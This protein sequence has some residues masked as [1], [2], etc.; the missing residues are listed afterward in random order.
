MRLRSSRRIV[1]AMVVLAVTPVLS[2]MIVFPGLGRGQARR[3]AESGLEEAVRTRAL[4]VDRA[5]ASIASGVARL[6]SRAGNA[7][8]SP[9]GP[10]ALEAVDDRY[11]PL[12]GGVVCRDLFVDPR[13]DLPATNVFVPAPLDAEQR[14]ELVRSERLDAA[15]DAFLREHRLATLVCLVTESGVERYA[16][17]AW[18][19]V[20]AVP[21]PQPLELFY[22]IASPR[23][24]PTHEPVWSRP[25]ETQDSKW[26]LT[27]AAP[28]LADGEFRG[29]VCADVPLRQLEHAVAGA[30]PVGSGV[31]RV[32]LRADG[33]AFT[34]MLPR[35]DAAL[36]AAIPR[37]L[38][39]PADGASLVRVPPASGRPGSFILHAPLPA[40]ALTLGAGIPASAPGSGAMLGAFFLAS[41]LALVLAVAIGVGLGMEVTRPLRRLARRARRALPG[42]RCADEIGCIGEAYYRMRRKM[43]DRHERLERMERSL[44]RSQRQFRVLVENVRDILYT[45]APDG[46]LTHANP[47]WETALGYAA[48]DVVGT[49]F[50]SLVHP[51]DRGKWE[52]L[53]H[54]TLR[55]ETRAE[56]V[57]Y[58]IADRQGN[59]R[60]HRSEGTRAPDCDRDGDVFLGVA[61]DVTEQQLMEKHLI[62]AQKMQSIGALAGGVA[63]DIGNLLTPMIGFSQLLRDHA[64]NRELIVEVADVIDTNL[65]KLDELTRRLLV[66]GRK[67]G[68][69]LRPMDLRF[70]VEE[71]RKLLDGS[72]PRG[73]RF[74]VHEKDEPLILRGDPNQIQQVLMNLCLNAVDAMPDGGVLRLE[75]SIVEADA[76]FRRTYP[77]AGAAPRFARVSVVDTGVGM[78]E[79]TTEKIFEPFFTTKESGKGTGLGLAMALKIVEDHGGLLHVESE[80]GRGTAFHVHLPLAEAKG[81]DG[82]AARAS[83]VSPRSAG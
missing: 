51:E 39:T 81:M 37:R 13:E 69:G 66:F 33:R 62:Q 50:A 57:L 42:L 17:F 24:N 16:P 22:D 29:V 20:R 76:S 77:R 23:R 63:H 27:C 2:V 74:E 44:E 80:I 75:T 60:W 35:E 68:A 52:E 36:A 65:G 5:L 1:T 9:I 18:T 31:P 26:I 25:I 82:S 7:L 71:T 34:E 72:I 30:L 38:A 45:V 70:A 59:W 32:W 19:P 53:F 47:S 48:D 83:S 28:V 78:D 58:R 46:I 21:E 3:A 41:T 56:P 8:D 67:S 73:V 10:G 54:S 15:F 64:D 4:E 11:A 6:A 61:R 40:V 12:A 49:R 14:A 43:I 55:D 79:E